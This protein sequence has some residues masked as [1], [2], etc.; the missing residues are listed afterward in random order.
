MSARIKNILAVIVGI[1]VGGVVNMSLIMMSSKIIPLPVGADFTTEAGLKAS[2]HLM[3]PKHFIIPFFAHALH[4]FI[5]SMIACK[6]VA[7]NQ[8]RIALI[9]GLITFLGGAQ[10]VF[11]LPSPMWFNVLDLG[12]AYFPMAFLGAK[13]VMKK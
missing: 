13:L 3:E 5:G 10:M 1:V 7:N 4:A 8:M 6:M 12:V 9:I 2:M 11:S